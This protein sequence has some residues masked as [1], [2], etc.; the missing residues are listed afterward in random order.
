MRY[1]LVVL[2]S[3]INRKTPKRIHEVARRAISGVAMVGAGNLHR[4]G[5]GLKYT[6]LDREILLA[7][8]RNTKWRMGFRATVAVCVRVGT[9]LKC[10]S[11]KTDFARSLARSQH[12]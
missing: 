9:Y 12:M 7:S 2:I 1:I 10:F 11:C 3:G 8:E 6:K 5:L 4:N